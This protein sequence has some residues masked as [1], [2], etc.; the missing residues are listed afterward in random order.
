MANVQ[1]NKFF[2]LPAGCGHVTCFCWLQYY[3]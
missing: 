1:L 3:T 2:Q